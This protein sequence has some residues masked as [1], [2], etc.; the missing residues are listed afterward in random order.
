MNQYYLWLSRILYYV[1]EMPIAAMSWSFSL[2]LIFSLSG[3]PVSGA[4]RGRSF[5]RIITGTIRD[6]ESGQGLPG[7]S[8]IVKGTPNGSIT[9]Q[10]GKFQL[11]V[12]EKAT[13]VIS[14]IGYQSV[15]K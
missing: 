8:I 14:F 2:L 4:N 3:A 13:I 15:E 7:V 1:D 10:D 9:D 5:D 12:P 6:S 11:S